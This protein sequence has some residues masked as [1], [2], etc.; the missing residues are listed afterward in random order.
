MTDKIGGYGRPGVDIS[1]SKARQVE[2]PQAS[3]KTDA[4]AR[5]ESSRDAVS[6]TDTAANLKRIEAGLANQPEVDRS[7][8]DAV[9]EKLESGNYAVDADKVAQKLLRLEQD[10]S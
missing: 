6:I 9:R 8:V 3:G 4:K 5:S 10:L 7:R 1:H 2:K